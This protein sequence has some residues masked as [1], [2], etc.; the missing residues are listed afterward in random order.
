M[1][2]TCGGGRKSFRP[3]GGKVSKAI[4]IA[5]QQTKRTQKSKTGGGLI[6]TNNRKKVTL[7]SVAKVVIKK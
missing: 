3:A 1:C 2:S 4:Q 7:T 5:T 6:Q